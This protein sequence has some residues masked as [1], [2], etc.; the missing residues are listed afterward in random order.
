V[1]DFSW[2][3]ILQVIGENIGGFLPIVLAALVVLFVGWIAALFVSRLVRRGMG[4]LGL[5]ERLGRW[6]EGPAGA[7]DVER[8]ASRVVYWL[9]M[10]LVSVAFFQTLRLTLITEPLNNLL[11]QVFAYLRTS[12]ARSYRVS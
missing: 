12:S 4:K 3:R 6:M 7:V 11:N 1:K 8:G 5:N 9:L 2:G 10:I